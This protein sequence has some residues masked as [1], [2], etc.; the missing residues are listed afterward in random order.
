M[1]NRAV[2]LLDEADKRPLSL[3]GVLDA[4]SIVCLLQVAALP[5]MAEH[6]A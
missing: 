3:Y 6:N 4:H 1:L 2:L 5:V